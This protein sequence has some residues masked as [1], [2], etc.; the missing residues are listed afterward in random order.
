MKYGVKV[1]SNGVEWI[2]D[3]V[4]DQ[5]LYTCHSG[6]YLF[7]IEFE[8]ID[9][10]LSENTTDGF[11]ALVSKTRRILDVLIVDNKE[12]WDSILAHEGFDCFVICVFG[13]A[14][15]IGVHEYTWSLNFFDLVALLLDGHESVKDA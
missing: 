6:C 15:W 13:D 8:A 4:I 12:W 10:T 3:L 11:F 7:I 9:I 5:F 2:R 1:T 14:Y